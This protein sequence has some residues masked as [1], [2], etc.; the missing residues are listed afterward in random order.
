MTWLVIEGILAIAR[1]DLR[2]FVSYRG[3]I[4]ALL[5]GPVVAITL[6]AY[7]AKLVPATAVSNGSYFDYVVVGIVALDVLTGAV[8]HLPGAVREELLVGTFERLVTSPLGAVRSVL[9][10]SLFPTFQA[11]IV[12]VVTVAFATVAFG[13]GV[14]FPG[15]LVAL[16]IAMLGAAAFLP[17]ALLG[18]A[19]ALAF[20]QAAGV[21]V[22]LVSGLSFVGGVYFPVRLL[23]GWIRWT[24]D[25]QPLTPALELL[26]HSIVDAPMTMSETSAI[27]RLAGFAVVLLPPGIYALHVSLNYGRRKATVTEY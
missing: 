14:D 8:G 22:L 15:A 2:V 17:F 20:K 27:L 13:F 25:V 21:S 16:P 24:S 12:S 10:M 4:V 23:P 1:R 19:A 26:R 11:F 6:F 18:A 7:V 5:I 3:R 9:G